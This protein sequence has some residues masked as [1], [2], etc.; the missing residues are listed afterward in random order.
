[1]PSNNKSSI[2]SQ[3]NAAQIA[4]SNALADAGMIKL[5]S[6]YGY[7]AAKLKQGQKLYDNARLALNVH[8]TM[9][10]EQQYKTSEVNKITKNAY[11]AYQALAKTARAVWQNDKPRLAALGLQGAMPRTTAGFLASAYVLFDNATKGEISASSNSAGTLAEYGY[12]KAKLTAER[13]KI[14]ALD[15]MN[16]AQEAAKGEAQNAARDQQ[17]ALKELNEWM[18]M[19]VKIAKVAL[20]SK[21]E[22]LEKLGI[23]ARSSKTKAQ[24]QA[25][26]KAKET[27]AK[28]KAGA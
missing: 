11:D 5:L 26:K 19:F 16:Q 15:K 7:T 8:K 22:Y 18:A 1:M 6:E 2:A 23:L 12:T 13:A 17:A 3:L 9:S 4:I 20:R 14:V 28:K 27:R 21:R 25:P 24:R 10:G